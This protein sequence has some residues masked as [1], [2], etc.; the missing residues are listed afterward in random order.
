MSLTWSD[1]EKAVA[2]R[3]EVFVFYSNIDPK[4]LKDTELPTDIHVV[5]YQYNGH[6]YCD[7]VRAPKKINIFDVYYDRLVNSGKVVAIKNGY[8]TVSPKM[9]GY[10]SKN[11]EK[12]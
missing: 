1:E 4:E 11:E 10:R 2:N 12:K 5:E 7:A 8:G 6:T 9:W 3:A